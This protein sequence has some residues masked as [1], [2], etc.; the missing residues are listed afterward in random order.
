MASSQQQQQQQQQQQPILLPKVEPRPRI[1]QQLQ[2]ADGGVVTVTARGVA[3]VSS[4]IKKDVNVRTSDFC[5]S[6]IFNL[7]DCNREFPEL[8]YLC[9]LSARIM[10]LSLLDDG[11][12]VTMIIDPTTFYQHGSQKMY[13]FKNY[14]Y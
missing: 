8:I 9:N 13:V 5:C 7:H 12:T 10:V 4:V 2:T 6:L 3:P 14:L 11:G 1:G